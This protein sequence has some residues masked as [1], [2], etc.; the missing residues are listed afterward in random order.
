MS[1]ECVQEGESTT[2]GM[3]M[4]DM[5]SGDVGDQ[6]MHQRARD[7]GASLAAGMQKLEQLHALIDRPWFCGRHAVSF[8]L[9]GAGRDMAIALIRSGDRLIGSWTARGE[10]LVFTSAGGTELRAE[11]LDSAVSITREFLER[12]KGH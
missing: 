2:T 3:D 12:A 4:K 1:F 6:R 10:M 8:E 9:R 11:M 5:I 7:A